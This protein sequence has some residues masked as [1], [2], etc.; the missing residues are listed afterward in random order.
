MAKL[1]KEKTPQDVFVPTLFRQPSLVEGRL[2]PAAYRATT[3]SA[4]HGSDEEEGIRIESKN[5]YR[6]QSLH[7]IAMDRT[8]DS[9]SAS[10]FNTNS[11]HSMALVSS[12]E[13][14][15]AVG[16][17]EETNPQVHSNS[18]TT[19]TRHSHATSEL[20]HSHQPQH[21]LFDDTSHLSID[22]NFIDEDVEIE[23]EVNDFLENNGSI[24]SPAV[25]RN[26][27][28]SRTSLGTIFRLTTGRSSHQA[29]ENL[30]ILEETEVSSDEK[31][32]SIVLKLLFCNCFRR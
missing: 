23:K 10:D 31:D 30:P 14:G 5:S 20:S 22:A 11:L 17:I 24:L 8:S 28:T 29:N 21:T 27:R 26:S 4:N 3:H 7:S 2:R 6:E 12:I 19:P 18:F 32:K 16:S 1:K 9:F 15:T 13:N 25:S